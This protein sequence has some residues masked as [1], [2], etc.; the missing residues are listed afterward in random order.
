M[1]DYTKH[2]FLFIF[3]VVFTVSIVTAFLVYVVG[4]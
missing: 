4:A 1:D 3:A 2:L